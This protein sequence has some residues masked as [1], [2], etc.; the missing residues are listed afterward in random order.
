MARRG[1][2]S[3]S[4]VQTTILLPPSELVGLLSH[5][6]AIDEVLVGNDTVVMRRDRRG[7]GVPLR[8]P[9]GR[10]A[11]TILDQKRL[12]RDT[13]L[14]HALT[15]LIHHGDLAPLRARAMVLPSRSTTKRSRVL[16]RSRVLELKVRTLVSFADAAPPREGP[17]RKLEFRL[18]DGLCGDDTNGLADVDQ[19]SC[20]RS[21]P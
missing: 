20:A 10:Y 8:D 4:L 18:T 12:S 21:W 17:H 19:L 7:E 15:L 16:D 6:T 5:R 3:D 1:L 9:G 13:V 14:A 2:R 11:V